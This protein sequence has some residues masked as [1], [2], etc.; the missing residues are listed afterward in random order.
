MGHKVR[1]GAPKGRAYECP[2]EV[3]KRVVELG[4]DKNIYWTSDPREAVNGADVV[5]TDTWYVS[6]I[7]LVEYML[8][9]GV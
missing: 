1:V 7:L 8:M 5:V 6:P 4:C 3:W 2:E 9:M